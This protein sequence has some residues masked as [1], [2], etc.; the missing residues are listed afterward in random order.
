M[1]IAKLKYAPLKEVIFE[2][3]WVGSINSEGVQTDIGFDLAQGK[4]A[5]NLKPNFPVHR[6]L[7]P[8][9]VPLKVFGAPVHQYW[10]GELHWPVV[11]HGQ[12]VLTVNETEAGYEWENSFKPLVLDIIQQLTSSYDETLQFNRVK[13]QYIDAWDLED[14]QDSLDFISNNLQTNIKSNYPVNG[15]LQNISL[16]Q[17]FDLENKSVLRLN[18]STGV[19]NQNQKKSVVWTTSIEKQALFSFEQIITWI[20]E[21]HTI[22]SAHF[23]QML[24]T[25]FYAALDK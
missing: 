21:A 17:Q 18:I 3:Y 9:G 7:L 1:S 12:C 24:N 4:L 5:A 13:L 16:H 11:Q 14:E 25:S 23:K 8:P 6:N 10:R 19:N 22:T 2:L 20:D 15:V